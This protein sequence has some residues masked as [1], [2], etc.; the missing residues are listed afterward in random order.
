M[1]IKYLKENKVLKV[2]IDVRTILLRHLNIK[3]KLSFFKRN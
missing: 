2:L 1:T 3:N